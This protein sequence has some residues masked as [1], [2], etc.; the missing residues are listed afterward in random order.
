MATHL[1]KNVIQSGSYIPGRNKSSLTM[2]NNRV[3]IQ[4][5]SNTSILGPSP[6]VI[7][8]LRNDVDTIKYYPDAS[9]RLFKETVSKKVGVKPENLL[10]GNGSAEIIDLINRA[11]LHEREEIII[12][13]PTF[14]KYE[15]SAQICNAKITKVDM[16]NGKHDL[17]G[18]LR[19][20][21]S[22]TKVI[23]IDTPCNP[24]GS[25]LS[26]NEIIS[27][28][29]NI[30]NHVTVV[31]D[32]AYYEFNDPENHIQYSKYLNLKNVLFMRS[33]SKAYGIAGLRIG[34]LIGNSELI[35][36]VNK[37]REVFNVNSLALLGGNAAIKDEEHLIKNIVLTHQQKGFLYT[38]LD[39]LGYSYQE[40]LG[41]F[42][43]IDTKREINTVDKFL[44]DR[45]LIVR[46]IQT[47]EKTSGL[48]RVTIGKPE[49]N[50]VFIDALR[51][52]KEI[53]P[54]SY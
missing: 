17:N 31:I 14:P 53:V 29:E 13:N 9:A 48:I 34:Y 22:S 24:V 26:K 16:V 43:L 47:K 18:I 40:S 36:Y 50:K 25:A 6:K 10:I 8:A 15:I 23:F 38:M 3:K 7:E 37:V 5:S 35:A 28:F 41:N 49:E 2:E 12:G 51:E 1:K 44:L 21:N 32:E 52:L 42:I 4:L 27:F 39:E 54:Q 19:S 30:P 11:L 20:I 46:P 33:L 45:G